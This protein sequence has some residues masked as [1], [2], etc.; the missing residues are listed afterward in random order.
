MCVHLVMKNT[1]LVAKTDIN[2]HTFLCHLRRR[3][4][5]CFAHICRLVQWPSFPFPKMLKTFP[6]FF[7]FLFFFLQRKSL[8]SM[9]KA[10]A[11]KVRNIASNKF[12]NP[13]D[14]NT[15]Y[16]NVQ[17]YMLQITCITLHFE[18]FPIIHRTKRM[19]INWNSENCHKTWGTMELNLSKHKANA[20]LI[21]SL[22]PSFKCISSL[23]GL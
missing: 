5:H 8:L 4:V 22:C 13:I 9:R 11:F 18:S 3:G 15:Y 7:W 23:I 6:P 14:M 12:T 20:T 16:Q 1:I 10:L 2:V 19:A 21:I 17:R